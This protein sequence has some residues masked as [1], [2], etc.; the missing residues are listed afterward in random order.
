MNKMDLHN[1]R[2]VVVLMLV[3]AVGTTS[4]CETL[5]K[6]FT[7]RKKNQVVQNEQ[8]AILDPIDYPDKVKSADQAYQ[9]HYSLWKVWMS[10]LTSIVEDNANE[11]KVLY[12]LGQIKEQLTAMRALLRETAQNQMDVYLK[13]VDDLSLEFEKSAA[14]RSKSAVVSR[15]R[16][17]SRNVRND[18]APQKVSQGLAAR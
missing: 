17:L 5:R 16:T 9:E 3:F 7:R 10:D 13:E 2:W 18:F 6:K 14:F 1:F 4:G 15:I 11:K 8:V 12:T